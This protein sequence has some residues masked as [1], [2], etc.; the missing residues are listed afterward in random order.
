MVVGNGLIGRSFERRFS[1]RSDVLI[2]ASGV[3]NSNETR[4]S[5]FNREWELLKSHI[6]EIDKAS[7]VVY[8]S[9]ISIYDPS[10]KDNPY[11]QHKLRIED[12]LQS[13]LSNYLIVRSPNVV[14]QGGN[15]ATLLNFLYWKIKNEEPFEVWEHA[16][17]NILHVDDFFTLVDRLIKDL[18]TTTTVDLIYPYSY[19]ILEIVAV[20]E[21]CL[22]KRAKF[23]VVNKGTSYVPSISDRV[24]QLYHEGGIYVNQDYLP[25][26]VRQVFGCA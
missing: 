20:M 1:E 12:Y 26:V 9:S 13:H 25:R 19:S 8:F 17:R 24:R 16:E 10:L 4:E 23:T 14:G 7:K 15:D 5:E 6:E 3:S 21:A 18:N 11:Q 2:F 22:L